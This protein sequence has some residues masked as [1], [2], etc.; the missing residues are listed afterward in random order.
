MASLRTVARKR[1]RTALLAAILCL[2]IAVSGGVFY[3]RS[4]TAGVRHDE[5][6]FFPEEDISEEAEESGLAVDIQ[7]VNVPQ[8]QL[9]LEQWAKSEQ[10]AA[11]QD[12]SVLNFLLCGVDTETGDA[13]GGRSDAMILIS[14]NKKKRH[15]T[16]T[17]FQRSSCMYI[18]LLRDPNNPRT[19]LGRITS[20]YS[21]GGPATL[22]AALS[23][24]YKLPIDAYVCVDFESFPKL[25]DSLDG[26][27]LDISQA[28]ADYI[29]TSAPSMQGVFPSG[30]AVTLSG[31]QAL[32]YSRVN[33]DS[34]SARAARLRSVILAILEQARQSSPGQILSAMSKVQRHVRTD[35]SDDAV[36]NLTKDALT[37]GWLNYTV[38]QLHSPASSAVRS[39]Y[40][41]EQ[42]MQIVNYPSEAARLQTEIYGYTNIENGKGTGGS[43]LAA[44]FQ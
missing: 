6:Y 29:N 19:Q 36:D 11:A 24:H 34:D 30:R 27:T 31:Q 35:L 37:Q 39:A 15:V 44:L 33:Y 9:S 10:P 26:I 41:N 21:L 25:I 3:Y 40:I 20:A 17:T 14:V 1:W 13:Q 42:H 43:Y 23:E 8:L 38:T 2:T 7:E 12:R 4:L 16:V 32:V 28:D 5:G 22:M 18:D